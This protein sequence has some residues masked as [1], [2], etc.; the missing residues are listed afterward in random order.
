VSKHGDFLLDVFDL[1]LC[2][3]EINDLDG[4][5]SLGGVFDPA[6]PG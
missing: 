1:I 6:C 3:L 5:H 2:F 4:D